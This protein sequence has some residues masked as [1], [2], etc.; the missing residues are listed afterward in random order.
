MKNCSK[1]NKVIG[2]DRLFCVC[3]GETVA[4]YYL[5]DECLDKFKKAGVV[6]A[7]VNSGG[8]RTAGVSYPTAHSSTRTE[9]KKNSNAGDSLRDLSIALSIIGIVG[10]GVCL[11]Q[12]YI[13]AGIAVIAVSA[14][15]GMIGGIFGNIFSEIINL[16]KDL[17]KDR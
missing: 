11:T 5:C 1:C 16:L 17:R 9:T 14:V 4:N 8:S 7:K 6:C 12:D 10:G 13:V 2:D 3:A 15:Y